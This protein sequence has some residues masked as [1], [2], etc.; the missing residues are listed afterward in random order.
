[1]ELNGWYQAELKIAE[2]KAIKFKMWFNNQKI[3]LVNGIEKMEM[4]PI[5]NTN[6]PD[7]II[8]E[9]PVFDGYLMLFYKNN[10]W[11]G[12]FKDNSRPG[13]YQLPLQLTKTISHDT[14]AAESSFSR[15][16]CRF[17]TGENA[18]PAIAEF[19][20]AKNN[21]AGTFL[22]ETGDYRYLHG[23]LL[24]NDSFYLSCFDGSHAFLFEGKM[25]NNKIDGVFYSGNHWQTTWTAFKNPEATLKNGFELTKITSNM[26]VQLSFIDEQKNVVSLQ[27]SAFLQQ[28]IIIQIMGTWCPNCLDE[29]NFFVEL[30]NQSTTKPKIIA[31]CFERGSDE[32]IQWARINKVKNNLNVPYPMLLAGKADKNAAT[33]LFPFLDKISSFPTTIFLNQKHEVVGIHTGFNGPA[34]GE[35]FEK[36]S[37]E[38]KELIT[39]LNSSK[40]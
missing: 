22:T 4:L 7:S 37:L 3:Y 34:T 21:I 5:K 35:K 40:Y 36:Q 39:I 12:F 28:P 38:F 2:G 24:Q 15:W 9:H 31:L 25:R 27:D 17:D 30:Y 6:N 14:V 11:Q 20:I 29:T 18:Y 1:M 13:N 32:Q 10:Q 8:I 26:P 23:E 33:L 16:E 19:T